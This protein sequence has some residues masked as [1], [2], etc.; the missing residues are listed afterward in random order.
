MDQQRLLYF[1]APCF[2]GIASAVLAVDFLTT[3]W[4]WD[5]IE[6]R[7]INYGDR[8]RWLSTKLG[9]GTAVVDY[10]YHPEAEFWADH[11]ASSFLN[12]NVRSHFEAGRARSWI[13]DSTEPSCA[14]LLRRELRN[15]FDYFNPRYEELVDWADKIDSARYEDINEAVDPSAPALMLNSTLELEPYETY[16]R[17]L[18][19]ALKQSPIADILALPA[20]QRRLKRANRLRLSGRDRFKGNAYLEDGIV[21]F[22]VDATGVTVNRY[23]PFYYWPNAR[24][25]AG[26]IRR[27]KEVKITAMQ[28]P[29]H[30]ASPISVGEICQRFNGGG[31]RRVGSILVSNRSSSEAREILTNLVTAIRNNTGHGPEA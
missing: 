30:D 13:Y 31:H 2:D 29:W 7:P 27:G 3:V 4:S 10:L 28:N 14:G 11:H 15:R 17:F 9:E 19:D 12:A 8:D 26:I 5:R 20:V 21:L 6:L 16:C 24:F 1:H 23:L 25:S 18:I 22:N